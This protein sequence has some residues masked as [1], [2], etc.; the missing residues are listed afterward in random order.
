MIIVVI[1]LI[2]CSQKE[3]QPSADAEALMDA[4]DIPPI[5]EQEPPAYTPYD[6]ETSQEKSYLIELSSDG[7]SPSEITAKEG[8]FVSII[9]NSPDADHKFSMPDFSIEEDVQKGTTKRVEIIVVSAGAYE[10]FCSKNCNSRG[11]LVVE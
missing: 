1:G 3:V 11:N 2:S 7:M 9:L 6:D 10:F 8:D 4:K 5:P